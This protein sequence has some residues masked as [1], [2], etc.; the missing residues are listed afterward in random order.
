[1]DRI[2]KNYLQE[3]INENSLESLNDSQKFEHFSGA[4]VT[5]THYTELFSSFDISIGGGDDC[6]LDCFA[7]LIN[8]SLVN[9]VDEVQ[10]LYETN[11]FI[12][13]TFVITQSES[14]SSFNSQKV[15]AI[16]N[17]IMDIFSEKPE[18]PQNNAIKT[19]IQI[20]NKIYSLSSKFRNGNPSLYIYYLTTG[21]WNEDRNLVQR[22][23]RLIKTISSLTLFKDVSFEYLGAYEIQNLYRQMRNSIEREIQFIN[24]TTLPDLPPEYEVQ[25]AYS[26]FLQ[27]NEFLKLIHNDREEIIHSIFYDNVRD[28]QEWNGINI[29]IK[30]TLIDSNKYVLFPLLNNGI[31]LVAKKIDVTGNKFLIKDYQI[32]NGCQ[33]SHVIHSS[34]DELIEGMLIPIKL[35]ATENEDVKNSITKATNRQTEITEE[36]LFALSD[37][38]K[39]LEQYFTTFTDNKKLYYERRSKQ[40]NFNP[41]V[42]KVRVINSTILIRSFAAMF[43]NLQHRTTRNYKLLQKQIGKDIF[44]DD[45]KLEMYYISAY[46]YYKMEYL[47]RSQILSPT[48]K[49]ARFA[50]LM[51]FKELAMN[52][53][54]QP[55][56]FNSKDMEKYCNRMMDILWDNERCKNLFIESSKI[57]LEISGDNYSTD[58]VRT[59]SFTN[60]IISYFKKEKVIQ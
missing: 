39:R 2:T 11:G 41:D 17:G 47:F 31:T 54:K 37:F 29:D 7:I 56:Y 27:I 40:Y 22:K 10:N 46:A 58:F 44:K 20:I 8:G 34:K 19:K 5:S 32:V 18:M 25:Q 60:L 26:G 9:D 4:I 57:I 23:K 35:I 15:G 1:M 33:T 6:G 24:K 48:L 49:A 16:E 28:F 38:P 30:E 21:S 13:C 45:H 12:E 53:L 52:N 36:Q 42:E 3:F 59:D 14:S 55:Q 43:L 51:I 50:L